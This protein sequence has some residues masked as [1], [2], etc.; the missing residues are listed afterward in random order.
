[1]LPL[2]DKNAIDYKFVNWENK[3][4]KNQAEDE[5][6]SGSN[7]FF[8]LLALI[9]YDLKSK[10][11][12]SWEEVIK[13]HDKWKKVCIEKH[14]NIEENEELWSQIELEVGKDPFRLIKA[15]LDVESIETD[16]KK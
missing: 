14:K 4:D 15:L 3:A 8:K 12:K 16:N 5:Y 7:P 9:Y 2:L 13:Q 6:I 10:R 1:M 11:G